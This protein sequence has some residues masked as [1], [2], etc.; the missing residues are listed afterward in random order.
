MRL[1]KTSLL[2]VAGLLIFAGCNTGLNFS[3]D[4]KHDRQAGGSSKRTAID[5]GYYKD[6]TAANPQLDKVTKDVF[7]QVINGDYV[8]GTSSL[9]FHALT[10]VV[11]YHSSEAGRGV[12]HHGRVYFNAFRDVL[13]KVKRNRR[14]RIGQV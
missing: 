11:E 5:G 7:L 12:E 10:G 1:I 13:E 9:R 6:F 14:F 3:S 8:N 4:K 2:V